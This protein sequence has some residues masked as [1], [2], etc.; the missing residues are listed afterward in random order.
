MADNTGE[1]FN[2]DSFKK[3]E[4]FQR[5][6]KQ[7]SN[8]LLNVWKSITSEVFG[9]SGAAFFGEIERSAETMETLAKESNKLKG[10]LEDAKLALGRDITAQ[11]Q[12][13]L[14]VI[15]DNSA[16]LLYDAGALGEKFE[17]VNLTKL[18]DEIDKISRSGGSLAET[19]EGF[20]TLEEQF[21][22]L[23]DLA[24]SNGEAIAGYSEETRES[25][26]LNTGLLSSLSNGHENL[27]NVQLEYNEALLEANKT[28][29]K[30]LDI[31]GGLNEMSENFRNSMIKGLFEWDKVSN[32]IQRDSGILLSEMDSVANADFTSGMAEFGMSLA[33]AGQMVGEIGEEL[34]TTSMATKDMALSWGAISMATG[35]ATKEVAELGANLIKMGYSTEGVKEY[36]EEAN[37]EARMLGV[38]SKNVLQSINKNL[39]KMK[40]FG[41][42]DGEESLAKMAARA[43][44]L[45]ISVDSIF[46]VAEKARTIEG[47]M[48]MAAD[49]QLAAGS[50]SNLNPMDLLAASRKGPKELQKII[51]TMGADIGRVNND[52]KFSL[53]PI[54]GDRLRIAAQAVGL[55]YEEMFSIIERNALDMEKLKMFNG[56]LDFTEMAKGLD[57]DPE[58][59]RSSFADMMESDGKGG[60]KLT[61]DGQAFL[62][63]NDINS[64]ANVNSTNLA[65]AFQQKKEDQKNID[66]Q[67][68]SNMSFRQSM[69]AFIASLT[70][71]ITVFQPMLEWMTQAISWFSS[72]GGT[73]TKSITAALVVAVP[74]IGLIIGRGISIAFAGKMSKSAGSGITA[75]A[76][77]LGAL[78][79]VKISIPGVARFALAVVLIGGAVVGFSAAMAQWGGEA[80]ADQM[81]TSA[82]SLL[83][84]AGGVAA[85]AAIG[86]K[87]NMKG[88]VK[89]SLA[90]FI[91]GAAMVPFAFALQMMSDVKWPAVIASLVFMA[92][93]IGMVFAIG[94]LLAGPQAILLA[95]GIGVILAIGGMM[96]LMAVSLM[97]AAVAFERL[98]N[99]NWDGISAMG[100]ALLSA[101]PGIAAFGLASLVFANPLV[102]LGMMAMAGSILMM[103]H[104]LDPLATNLERAAEAMSKFADSMK[105]LK[106]TLGQIDTKKLEE[107]QKIADAMSTSSSA[108]SLNA[109]AAA[110]S[111]AV[112]GGSGGASG[113]VRKIEIKLIGENGREIKH[114]ILK[115]TATQSGR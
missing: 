44:Q 21:R 3:Y 76:K 108:N 64:L 41:F 17:D 29:E 85:M 87:T 15:S 61:T 25:I 84:L 111:S 107:M 37:S 1:V 94:A 20:N 53:D 14:K 104:A 81:A 11:L 66:A 74:L 115:D 40:S 39:T 91:I 51:A 45:R 109:L 43:E 93:S 86:A 7:D 56:G 60:F 12:G 71:T 22:V 72:L 103:G 113:D 59:L 112:S 5:K 18:Q 89:G 82:V 30:G 95:I 42:T 92:A 16:S 73:F 77:S 49:L 88:V 23:E 34:Q 50:F 78:S 67:A 27:I 10:N 62:D 83:I 38:N 80:S 70:N 96:V 31:M 63:K 69:D 97:I 106:A 19:L 26:L 48:Q 90:M 6:Q 99:V 65:A 102:L 105:E 36:F 8:A 54:D 33:D 35:V 47:A 2:E 55:E 110:L 68:A 24:S 79:K 28:S 52:G 101:A 32:G 46:N 114:K 13:S 75:L 57:M 98:A 9:V 4:E 58:A 100:G